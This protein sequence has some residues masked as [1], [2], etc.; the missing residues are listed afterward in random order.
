MT[1]DTLMED[2]EHR[3]KLAGELARF[4]DGRQGLGLGTAL[5]GLLALLDPLLIW[6]GSNQLANYSHR[7]TTQ[8]TFWAFYAPLVVLFI[9]A[10]ALVDAFAW[11]LLKDALQA[12][13]YRGHG[14]AGSAMPSWEGRVGAMLLAV[15]GCVGLWIGGSALMELRVPAGPE[16]SPLSLWGVPMLKLVGSVA[17]LGTVALLAAAWRRVRG[18]RNWLGWVALCAPFF[19][20]MSAPLL[21]HRHPSVF[22]VVLLLALMAACLYLPF[23]ALYVGLR[24]HLRYRRLLKE[25]GALTAIEENL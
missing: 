24:D 1:T 23:M 17:L 22:A 11:L 18:W 12:R 6:L 3:K 2:L 13:L 9:S 20:F 19:F 25:L 7:H 8:A 21:D 5:A 10:V 14:E 4:A 15:L 16:P